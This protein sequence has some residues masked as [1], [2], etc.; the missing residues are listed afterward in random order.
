MTDQ[1]DG[2]GAAEEMSGVPDTPEEHNGPASPSSTPGGEPS[3]VDGAAEEGV[4]VE[5]Q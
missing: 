4:G 2:R 5:D 1:E 3:R